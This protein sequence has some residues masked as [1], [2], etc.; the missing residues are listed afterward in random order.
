[1]RS[2]VTSNPLL[3][4][5]LAMTSLAGLACLCVLTPVLA[6]G[7]D[8]PARGPGLFTVYNHLAGES[9]INWTTCGDNG[10]G[11]G[12]WGSGQI[13]PFAHACAIV[14]MADLVVV[15]DS[16]DPASAVGAAL[17]IYRESNGTAPSV[18]FLRRIALDGLPA[19]ST[20]K[21]WAAAVR[22]Q[23][24]LGT[25]QSVRYHAI[26]LANDRVTSGEIC[27]NP[28]DNVSSDGEY[29]VVQQGNCAGYFSRGGLQITNGTYGKAFFPNANASV[30]IP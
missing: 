23:L 30:P 7:P 29:V 9:R 17:V 24:Y 11:M 2:T 3:R 22:N 1:M 20:A 5:R 14:R 4:A 13:G 25:D 28:T 10:S 6:A 19:S 26:N 21:C 18:D 12:C 15:V 16:G 8:A 27:G